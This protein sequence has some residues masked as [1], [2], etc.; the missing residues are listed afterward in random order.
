MKKVEV[1]LKWKVSMLER[2]Y[3]TKKGAY[4]MSFFVASLRG[5]EVFMMDAAVL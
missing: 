3:L 2:R 5:S 1:E 4:F